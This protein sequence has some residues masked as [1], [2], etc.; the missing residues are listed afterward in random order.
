MRYTAGHPPVQAMLQ[1]FLGIKVPERP[2]VGPKR[3]AKD[4][5]TA[6]AEMEAQFKDVPDTWKN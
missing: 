4:F 3:Q 1:A 5:E 6:W 2:R